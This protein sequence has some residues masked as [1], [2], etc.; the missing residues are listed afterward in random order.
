MSSL[1]SGIAC[2]ALATARVENLRLCIAILDPACC[3]TRYPPRSVR[4]FALRHLYGALVG[5]NCSVF[6]MSDGGP[7]CSS[8]SGGGLHYRTLSIA[9]GG[10]SQRTRPC[11]A[12]ACRCWRHSA[13]SKVGS[14]RRWVEAASTRLFLY[15]YKSA[16]GFLLG[17]S[18]A[19]ITKTGSHRLCSAIKLLA[20]LER[21][22][23][24]AASEGERACRASSLPCERFERSFCG[25][26]RSRT[27][28]KLNPVWGKKLIAAPRGAALNRRVCT[29][30]LS[31]AS[32]A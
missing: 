6:E 15:S 29:R 32:L 14:C 16:A 27:P 28:R 10:Q 5:R 21:R 23:S 18:Q 9:A 31:L 11:S 2:M 8:E 19:S 7:R 13:T 17:P 26:R 1:V 20:R 22:A 12:K 24:E 30:S 25:S 4:R 3:P